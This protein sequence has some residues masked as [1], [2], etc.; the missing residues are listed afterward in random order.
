[1]LSCGV[2]VNAGR[3]EQGHG[4]AEKNSGGLVGA[5]EKSWKRTHKKLLTPIHR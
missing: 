5:A 1:M 4:V 2:Y 3:M